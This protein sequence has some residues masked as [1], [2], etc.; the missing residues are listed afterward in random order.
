MGSKQ[1]FRYL[2]KWAV[3]GFMVVLQ[4]INGTASG[5]KN[6]GEDYT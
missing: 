1:Q 5:Q 2:L 3:C 6:G 4:V